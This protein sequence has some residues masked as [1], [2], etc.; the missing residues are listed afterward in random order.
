MAFPII[1]L[2]IGTAVG[3]LATYIYKD[4]TTR[5]RIKST[6]NQ[7]S[8]KVKSFF[9]SKQN[10]EAETSDNNQTDAKTATS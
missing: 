6:T 8:E 7:V 1:P 3:S 5:E 10:A 9:Q 2:A 4:E